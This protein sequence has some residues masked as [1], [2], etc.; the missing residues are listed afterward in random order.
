MCGD[1]GREGCRLCAR[2]NRLPVNGRK[3][4]MRFEL[5][6]TRALGRVNVQNLYKS[7]DV[8]TCVDHKQR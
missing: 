7:I 4:V 2:G 5:V 3:E 6:N 8:S 1:A